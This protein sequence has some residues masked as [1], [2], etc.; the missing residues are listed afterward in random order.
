MLTPY[1]GELPTE[2]DNALGWFYVGFSEPV[3]SVIMRS[4][5]STNP[6]KTLPFGIAASCVLFAQR[7]RV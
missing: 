6:D 5:L 1:L 3:V 7:Q 2:K 4:G